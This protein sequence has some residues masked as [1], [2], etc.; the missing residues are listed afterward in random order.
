MLIMGK[1]CDI[2][3]NCVKITLK[4]K[5][6]S[7]KPK[8]IWLSFVAYGI[9][10]YRCRTIIQHRNKKIDYNLWY[11]YMG[12]ELLWGSITLFI[13]AGIIALLMHIFSKYSSALEFAI[14]ILGLIYLYFGGVILAY[15][16]DD[17]KI[18]NL[19]N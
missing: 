10:S 11:R 12:F 1:K 19:G 4:E 2:I 15:K 5:E 9:I 3:N 13:P 16:L 7:D 17:W 14:N 18:K 8:Y 6:M